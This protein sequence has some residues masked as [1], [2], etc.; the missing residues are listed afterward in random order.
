MW[1]GPVWVTMSVWHYASLFKC[2]LPL[3]LFYR[4]DLVVV[5]W[6]YH[7]ICTYNVKEKRQSREEKRGEAHYR[8]LMRYSETITCWSAPTWQLVV[9]CIWLSCGSVLGLIWPTV[10]CPPVVRP[11]V[12]HFCLSL[13]HMQS[14]HVYKLHIKKCTDYIY[15]CCSTYLFYTISKVC[16]HV[17]LYHVT[18]WRFGVVHRKTEH[19]VKPLAKHEVEHYNEGSTLSEC[20]TE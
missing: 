5:L 13:S 12:C 15:L 11:P 6:P 8:M 18:N 20:S 16:Y 2:F 3:A 7:C 14:A 9:G 10:S 4:C 19:W 1:R 17:M